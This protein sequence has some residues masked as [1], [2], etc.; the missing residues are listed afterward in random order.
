[1]VTG[2]CRLF[3]IEQKGY[4]LRFHNANLSSQ[5]WIDPS[6]REDSLAFFRDYL[7]EGD[8]VVDI[9]AN[10]GD[11][12]L[13]AS[14][15]VGPT[16]R[17]VG[18]E[19][20]PRTFEF[21]EDNIRLNGVTNV[22]LINSAVGATSGTIQF[23]DDK[24]DDMNRVG[25][26]DL[27]VAIDRLDA[28]IPEALPVAL[29]KVDVEG[30]EKFVLE[31]APEV[32]RRSQSVFFEVSALHFSQFG[33]MT[34]DVLCLLLDAGFRLYRISGATG[35]DPITTDFDTEHFENLVALRDE[36]DFR[37]RTSW[38]IAGL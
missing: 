14:I 12:V 13:T 17:V 6:E 20:H 5:L 23:S 32:L 21:L 19:A 30:Y 11:T 15:Q 36:A 8:R 2:L 37:R 29:L 35:L 31:G 26:G 16:G 4:R 25:G 34:R 3:V 33:Y 22:T 28:L 18:I 7:K 1:M 24:R 38:V 27:E 10:V 9:G